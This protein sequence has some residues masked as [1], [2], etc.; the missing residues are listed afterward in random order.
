M[1]DLPPAVQ[2]AVKEQAK[3]GK[4]RGLTKEV[5]EGKTFY[6]AELR[7]NG[8][9]RDVTFDETGAL[10]SVEQEVALATAPPAVRAALEQMKGN[11]K[12]IRF[13]QVTAGPKVYYEADIRKAGKETEVK[14]DPDG[15]VIE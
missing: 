2:A 10:V 4:L 5:K 15:K 12:I 7:V 1:A 8:K 3:A 13:E 11:G 9:T 14:L 6:E